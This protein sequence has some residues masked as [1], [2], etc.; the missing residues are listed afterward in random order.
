MVDWRRFVPADFEYDEEADH[1]GEHGVTFGEA[2]ECFYNE[3]Q[4]RRNKR[5]R[6][7]WQLVGRT[8]SG[9]KLKLIF[10]LKPRRVVRI[11]TG[12]FI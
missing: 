2:T 6:D 5:Y 11:I 10:A 4:I 8:D 7:R 1:L 3:H 12:W 9:R